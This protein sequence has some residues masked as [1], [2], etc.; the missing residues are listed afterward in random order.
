MTLDINSIISNTFYIILI[1]SAMPLIT[2]LTIGLLVSVFQAVTQIQ[3]ASLAFIPKVVAVFIVIL[4]SLN[5]SL[6]V[7]Q[8]FSIELFQQISEYGKK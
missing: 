2:S 6:E 3:D 5:W 4:L 8:T 7:L 1:L